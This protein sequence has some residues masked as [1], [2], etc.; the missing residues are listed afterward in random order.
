MSCCRRLGQIRR[1]HPK[2]RQNALLIRPSYAVAMRLVILFTLSCVYMYIAAPVSATAPVAAAP[3]AAPSAA[4]SSAPSAAPFGGTLDPLGCSFLGRVGGAFLG[5]FVGPL[6]GPRRRC[7]S[8]RRPVAA[9]SPIASPVAAPVAS[10]V[11]SPVAAPV[12]VP[13]RE[14]TPSAPSSL[15][16]AAAPPACRAG[17]GGA[18][19]LQRQI[20][21][22]LP[23]AG[24]AFCIATV[25]QGSVRL[26]SSR[27]RSST[28]TLEEEEQHQPCAARRVGRERPER[29]ERE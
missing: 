22:A 24:A 18:A 5:S 19:T 11:A 1:H 8:G 4:P 17:L 6:G 28:G 21:P 7:V 14:K 15:R 2:S 9:A 29:S 13:T 12:A 26:R 10:P 20:S 3:V 16:G 23:S 27:S 25:A